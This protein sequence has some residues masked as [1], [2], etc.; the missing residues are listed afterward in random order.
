MKSKPPYKPVEGKTYSLFG[1]SDSTSDYYRNIRE[2]ADRIVSVNTDIPLLID[3]IRRFSMRRSRLRRAL[4]Q[5]SGGSG[6]GD[7]LCMIDPVL[8]IYTG[9]VGDHLQKVPISKLCDRTLT[10]SREQYHLHM[11]EIELINR[12]FIRDF[13]RCDTK[14]ALLPYCLQDFSTDCKAARN[15][16][17]YQCRHCSGACFQNHASRILRDHNIEPYIWMEGD[18]KRLASSSLKAN[19]TFGVLGIACIPELIRGMRNC[20]KNKIPVIGLPLNANRCRRW[21]GEF[22]PNSIDLDE[23]E[24]MLLA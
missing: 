16:F 12:T 8:K 2:L 5:K 13:V 15:G 22:L 11:L 4:E 19:H 24:R 9:K 18:M 21:F 6:A 1:N 10:E 14:I 23:L 3:A 20:M 7:I 17:D